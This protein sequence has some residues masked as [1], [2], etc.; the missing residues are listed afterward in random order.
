MQQNLQK[1][2]KTA[3]SP[4]VG[5]LKKELIYSFVMIKNLLSLQSEASEQLHTPGTQLFLVQ[6][7]FC[8]LTVVTK[9]DIPPI[10]ISNCS[11]NLWSIFQFLGIYLE[12]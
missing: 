4:S 9:G 5:L 1:I 6:L 12:Y 11:P 8:V 3:G 10:V 7:L 2:N